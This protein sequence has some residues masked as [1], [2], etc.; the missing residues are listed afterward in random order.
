MGLQNQAFYRVAPTCSIRGRWSPV[1]VGKLGENWWF[2]IYNLCPKR[3]VGMLRASLIIYSYLVASET[4][5]PLQVLIWVPG[6]AYLGTFDLL[7]LWNVPVDIPSLE[8]DKYCLSH[9]G[10]LP[11]VILSH[12]ESSWHLLSR[13]ILS[14]F[15]E[16]QWGYWI[17]ATRLA[18]GRVGRFYLMGSNLSCAGRGNWRWS[19]WGRAWSSTGNQSS[20]W[21]DL[22]RWLKH[23]YLR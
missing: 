5:W 8:S 1:S 17:K 2:L 11:W 3:D 15:S 6:L 4:F 21:W 16:F 10:D 23:D 19:R 20:M 14:H 18:D 9:L 12:L 7:C 13:V 22:V